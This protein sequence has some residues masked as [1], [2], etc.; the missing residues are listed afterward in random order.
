M[1]KSRILRPDATA[2]PLPLPPAKLPPEE[3]LNALNRMN[4]QAEKRVKLGQQL[5]LAAEAQ[6]SE[7]KKL[8]DEF[9]GENNRLR[10]ELHTDLGKTIHSYDRWVGQMDSRF[11]QSLIDIEDRMS[12]LQQDWER[13]QDRIE[14][15]LRRSEKLLDEGKRLLDEEEK[16]VGITSPVSAAPTAAPVKIDASPSVAPAAKAIVPPLMIGGIDESFAGPLIEGDFL[17]P[18]ALG[19]TEAMLDG[20]K[21]SMILPPME[22][23]LTGEAAVRKSVA[24]KDASLA[25]PSSPEPAPTAEPVKEPADEAPISPVARRHKFFSRV[26]A[27]LDEIERQKTAD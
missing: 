8:V 18:A 10:E 15:M 22:P 19:V 25:A 9:R 23:T 1:S 4:D 3:Q 5:F 11:N 7:Y 26:L 27:K 16:H 24:I 12:R 13:A 21:P 2:E 17:A 20:L 14:A 6:A